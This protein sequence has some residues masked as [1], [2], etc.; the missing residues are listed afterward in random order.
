MKSPQWYS[1]TKLVAVILARVDAAKPVV[2]EV[3]AAWAAPE[4]H[5]RIRGY[6]ERTVGRKR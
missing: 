2:P 3:Q 1:F 6:L 5:E 4:T